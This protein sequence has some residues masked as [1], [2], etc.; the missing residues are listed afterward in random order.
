MSD[1]FDH[2]FEA[3]EDFDAREG[4]DIG[5]DIDSITFEEALFP[6]NILDDFFS[7]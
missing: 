7:E 4:C 2:A 1:T 3:L 6:E 5:Q